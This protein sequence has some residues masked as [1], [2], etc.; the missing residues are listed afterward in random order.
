L[1]D[2]GLIHEQGTEI[3]VS[4]KTEQIIRKF[5][6]DSQQKSKLLSLLT[7]RKVD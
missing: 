3:Y 1:S 4:E 7:A 5:Y 2:E 6:S